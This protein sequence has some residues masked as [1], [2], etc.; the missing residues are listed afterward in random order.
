MIERVL[1]AGLG[2]IGQRHLR[3]L[4]QRLP[5]AS[6]MALRH[7]RA[8]DPIAGIDVTTTSLDDALAFD[9]QIA[10]VATPAPF[11]ANT[12]IALANRGVHLLVEKPLSDTAQDARRLM[13]AAEASGVVLQTGYNLRFKHSL[14]HFRKALHAGKIGRVASIRAEVGQYLPD[15]RPGTDW[16]TSVSAR[17]DL[18]GGVLLELSHEIDYQRWIFGE[19]HEASAWMGQQGAWGLDVEDTV[20]AI[21]KFTGPIPTD[22]TGASPVASLTLDFI[23]R[24]TVRRCE[25]VGEAG[26][27]TWDGVA[28]EVRLTGPEGCDTTHFPA[29]KDRDASYIA[30]LD[31]FLDQIRSG[32][33]AGASA[34]DGVEVL[35]IADAIRRSSETGSSVTLPDQAG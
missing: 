11:H 22:Q 32:T 31:A 25:A 13:Q 27:L 21:L 3:L 33:A 19:V 8:S 12:A 7:S 6:F 1:I 23:R 9:P 17:G 15:W 30:Q 26:T 5:D 28:S 2:S 4:R 16:R 10:I 34:A 29:D 20:H 24:D 18:G 14:T 35:E